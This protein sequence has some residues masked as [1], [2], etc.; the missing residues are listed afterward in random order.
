MPWQT[1]L[2]GILFLKCQPVYVMPLLR[3]HERQICAVKP[4]GGGVC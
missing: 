1:L 3:K 4:D 2:P